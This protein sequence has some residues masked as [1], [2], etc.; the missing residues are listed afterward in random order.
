[1]VEKRGVGTGW[2]GFGLRVASSAIPSSR[3]GAGRCAVRF[4]CCPLPPLKSWL[5]LDHG[6]FHMPG[7]LLRARPPASPDSP[8]RAGPSGNPTATWRASGGTWPL[9][10]A[11]H[12]GGG[13]TL[14]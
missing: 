12:V 10:L 11:T 6:F 14:G 9:V 4:P 2:P 13:F 3:R 7:L 1:V 8:S 5:G